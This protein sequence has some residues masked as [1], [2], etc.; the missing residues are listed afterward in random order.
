MTPNIQAAKRT[1]PMFAQLGSGC[2]GVVAGHASGCEVPDDSV[3]VDVGGVALS[4][5]D[6]VVA[7]A[8]QRRV[9]Q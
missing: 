6:L 4:V 7:S 3:E 2:C 1:Q 9:D 5:D 8:Q